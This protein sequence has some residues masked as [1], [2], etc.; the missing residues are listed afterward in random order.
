[1]GRGFLVTVRGR[2]ERQFTN[3]FGP[4]E[5]AAC[6]QNTM[7]RGHSV[8]QSNLDGIL[9]YFRDLG[10]ELISVETWDEPAPETTSGSESNERQ[11]GQ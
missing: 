8:D 7:V 9:A 6:G 10:I 11:R 3:V 1:M 5:I 4:A 2:L